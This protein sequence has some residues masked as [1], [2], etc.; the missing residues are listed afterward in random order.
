M[1]IQWCE[2]GGL[3]DTTLEQTEFASAVLEGM[4][5]PQK[6][7]P[8]KFFYDRK[9]SE[10]FD[11][12]CDSPEY[13]ITRTEISILQERTPNVADLAGDLVAIFE[14][15]SGTSRKTRILLEAMPHAAAYIPIDITR[16]TLIESA[17]E[18]A[19]A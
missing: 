18:L 19:G 14:L 5:Q 2:V 16:D 10:L 3:R 15:G 13:Y 17:H 11:R 9:G 12:L 7:L 1:A 6:T 4:A 8:P